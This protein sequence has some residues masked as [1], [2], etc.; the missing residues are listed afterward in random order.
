MSDSAIVVV[1]AEIGN[2][3]CEPDVAYDSKADKMLLEKRRH[4]KIFFDA[5]VVHESE[6]LYDCHHI[7]KFIS[8]R[9]TATRGRGASPVVV[10]VLSLNIWHL[11]CA[12]FYALL[13]ALFFCCWIALTAETPFKPRI[14]L[15]T[16]RTRKRAFSFWLRHA[17]LSVRT[18]R[19]LMYRHCM[20]DEIRCYQWVC[21]YFKRKIIGKLDSHWCDLYK[22]SFL[23]M[24]RSDG[25]ERNPLLFCAVETLDFV[26]CA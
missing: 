12:S 6:K 7:C 1:C 22:N 3:F 10:Q 14:R 16:H 8:P 4:K 19:N 2:L 18:D 5:R 21:W 20:T 15:H 11:T 26:Y 17:S 24:L 25:E 9:I 13:L 23:N